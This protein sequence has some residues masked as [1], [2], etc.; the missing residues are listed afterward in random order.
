MVGEILFPGRLGLWFGDGFGR[1]MEVFA[2]V[3]AGLFLVL[4]V[5]LQAYGSFALSMG[6]RFSPVWA[7]AARDA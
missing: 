5:S 1:T 3:D 6:E 4:M 7:V 2:T